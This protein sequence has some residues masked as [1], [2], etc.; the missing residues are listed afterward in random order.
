MIHEHFNSPT[1]VLANMT[2]DDFSN[3][4]VEFRKGKFYSEKLTEWF[5]NYWEKGFHF[6]NLFSSMEFQHR[7]HIELRKEFK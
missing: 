7:V 6:E 2:Q 5:L 1:C 4:D 3:P